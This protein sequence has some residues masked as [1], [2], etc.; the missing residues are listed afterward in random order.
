MK[1]IAVLLA[2]IAS[3][4]ILAACGGGDDN[5][6]VAS[7]D[8]TLKTTTSTAAAAGQ[9]L[10]LSKNDELGQFLV[11]PNGHTLYLFE[12]DS[13]TTSA[14]ATGGCAAT[15]PALAAA[16]PTAA[17]GIDQSKVST[18]NGAVPNQVVY[19]G[20]LL[21]YFSGDKAAGDTNGIGIP[22]WYPVAPSGD[23]ID[24]D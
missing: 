14:C 9:T 2:V 18:A 1:R 3:A 6:S 7:S 17:S 10:A 23:K 12:K 24:K 5:P 4:G 16:K 8:T 22:E 21:Y 11:G 13:G 19:N 15:W 20:H